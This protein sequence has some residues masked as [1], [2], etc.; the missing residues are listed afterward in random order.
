MHL[1]TADGFLGDVE[2]MQENCSEG[3][4]SLKLR[5]EGDTLVQW[6]CREW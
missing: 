6:E 3:I 1:Y 5:Y 4:F 2:K